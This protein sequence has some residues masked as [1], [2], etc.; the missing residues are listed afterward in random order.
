LSA[1]SL[2]IDLNGKR[3]VLAQLLALLDKECAALESSLEAAVDAA[4]NEES[5]PENEYDTRAL[6]ASYLAGAQKERL[7]QLKGMR[8]ALAAMPVKSHAPD[9]PVQTGSIVEL[10]S[11]GGQSV[12]FLLQFAAGYALD[13]RGR[14]IRTVTTQSPLGQA[15]LGKAP[16]DLIAIQVGTPGAG[17]NRGNDLEYEIVSVW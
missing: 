7:E 11:E 8:L 15:L 6:E 3:Q 17:T 12:C 2:K 14:K 13:F 10:E 9:G 1:N 16:G 5:K 4:T